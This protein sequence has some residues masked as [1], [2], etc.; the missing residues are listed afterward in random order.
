MN[1]GK[2]YVKLINIS[3]GA[4]SV[5]LNLQGL[6]F[7]KDFSVETLKSTNLNDYNTISNP[8]FIY[9]ATK[10][11]SIT[12]KKIN[13]AVEPISVNVFILNYRK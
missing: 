6:S 11:L 10:I 12:G 8:K 9:P 4:K 3:A 13:I 1:S 2:V 7:S 5:S